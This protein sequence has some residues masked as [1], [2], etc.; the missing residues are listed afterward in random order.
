MFSELDA[1]SISKASSPIKILAFDY[2]SRR[3]LTLYKQPGLQVFDLW[4]LLN[5]NS[6]LLIGIPSL[7]C[8]FE[9]NL[10]NARSKASF[11]EKADYLGRMDDLAWLNESGVVSY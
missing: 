5:V 3:S 9:L 4:P 8:K 1:G 11:R 2:K 10:Q 7:R 6:S